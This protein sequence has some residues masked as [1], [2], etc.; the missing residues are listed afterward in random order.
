V[1]SVEQFIDSASRRRCIASSA[2]GRSKPRDGGLDYLKV[3]VEN[4]YRTADV[5]RALWLVLELLPEP[6]PMRSEILERGA[7]PQGQIPIDN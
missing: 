5:E 4:L 6:Q 2:P 7:I 1:E 3:F